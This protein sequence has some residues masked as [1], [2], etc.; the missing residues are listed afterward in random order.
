MQTRIVIVGLLFALI[1]VSGLVLSSAGKPYNQL[2]FTAHKLIALGVLV[3]LIVT[4]HQTNVTSGLSTLHWMAVFG[5]VL[6]VIGMFITGAV[7]S[8][9]TPAPPFVLTLHQ[10]LPFLI[11]LAGSFTLYLLAGS[12]SAV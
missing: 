12:S 7:L 5:T 2:L 3:L 8:F 9:D 6:F 4:V 10:I 1:V 11:V